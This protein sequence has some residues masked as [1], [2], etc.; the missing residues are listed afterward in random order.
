MLPPA[1]KKYMT[2][3]RRRQSDSLHIKRG[4]DANIINAQNETIFELDEVQWTKAY[5]FIHW[6]LHKYP[7][8]SKKQ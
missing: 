2:V 6:I 3:L 5:F 4:L 8:K 7:T 1:R